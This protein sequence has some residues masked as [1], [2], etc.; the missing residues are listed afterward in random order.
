MAETSQQHPQTP[1]QPPL[2]VGVDVGGTNIKIG[3]VDDAGQSLAYRSIPTE[4]ERGPEDGVQRIAQAVETLLLENDLRP[5]RVA[6]IGLATPGTMDTQA[7]V[8]LEP[9]NLPKWF[10]FPIRDALANAAGHDV[11]FVND[12]NAAAYGEYW[13]GSGQEFRSLVF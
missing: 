4:S 7:G 8:L 10:N 2:F 6:R 3:L 9:H 1:A 11:T 5:S 12:A 13:C